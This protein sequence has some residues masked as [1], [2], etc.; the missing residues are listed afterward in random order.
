MRSEKTL[1][2]KRASLDLLGRRN[3]LTILIKADSSGVQM[4]FVGMTGYI[5]TILKILC[6]TFAGVMLQVLANLGS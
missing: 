3:E 1:A 2:L 6:P 4:L 5:T